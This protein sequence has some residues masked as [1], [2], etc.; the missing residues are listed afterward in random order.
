MFGYIMVNK[1]ELRIKDFDRYRSY[2]CGLC[3]ALKE[4]CG[5]RGQCALSYDLTFLAILLNG[6]YEFSCEEKKEYCILH[7][8]NKQDVRRSEATNYVADMTLLLTWYKC[9]DDFSD[10]KKLGKGIYG[11]S[12]EKKVN[13]IKKS[14]TRQ[15]NVIKENLDK[16]LTLEKEKCNDI[17]KLSGC[18]GTLLAEVF[19]LKAD[20]WE[21]YL[22]KI[23]FFMGKFIYILDAYDDLEHDRKKGYFNPFLLKEKENLEEWVKQLLMMAASEFAKEFEKLPI[24]EDVELLRNIIYSGV[25][26][27]YEYITKTRRAGGKK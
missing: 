23:G 5:L 15:E 22:R 16:L 17:D 3:K 27:R 19:V 25:W 14:Y 10:E 8:L 18:F 26:T 4:R 6:L 21:S 2:Y 9:K 7:L 1:P 11:K 12:I 20:E 24:I 13:Q